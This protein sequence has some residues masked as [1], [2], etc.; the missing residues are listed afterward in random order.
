MT[1]ANMRA[2]GV[3]LAV[4]DLRA[5]PPQGSDERGPPGG[6]SATRENVSER[7]SDQPNRNGYDA[8]NEDAVAVPPNE[9]K[10]QNPLCSPRLWGGRG[11][12]G[13]YA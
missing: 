7:T 10:Q 5:M 2:Q 1:L 4:G 11:V 12:R 6:A 9:P 13:R 8:I 3:A